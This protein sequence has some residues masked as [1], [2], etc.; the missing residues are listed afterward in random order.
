MKI[1]YTQQKPVMLYRYILQ[2]ICDQRHEDT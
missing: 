1:E 2:K